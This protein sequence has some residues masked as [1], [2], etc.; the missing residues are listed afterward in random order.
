MELV[1]IV[2][3]RP[4]FIKAWPFSQAVQ[5]AGFKELLVHTGQ[6]YDDAMSDVFFRELGMKAPDVNLAVGSGPHGW[7]TAQMIQG[8]EPLLAA[9]RPNWV[10]VFGDTNTT[11]AGALTAAKLDLPIAHVEAGLRSFR[12]SMPEEINRV[13]T[14]HLSTLLFA[15]TAQAMKNLEREGLLSRAVQVGDI[16]AEA[17]VTARQFARTRSAIIDRL[18][19]QEGYYFVATVH[20]AENTDNPERLADIVSAFCQMPL[21]VIFPVHPRT[22]S[23]IAAIHEKIGAIRLIDPVGYFDML[24]LVDGSRLVLT[25]SGGL[26]KEAYWSGKPCVILRKETEWVELTNP[27]QNQLVGHQKEA[28]LNAVAK[29]L[30]T[31]MP[32]PNPNPLLDLRG[33]ASRICSA[34]ALAAIPEQS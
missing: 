19:L 1:T 12:R 16:M 27:G 26:Q 15:P 4:Q 29:L 32:T 21:P 10:I 7:Q 2:G 9:R 6:H 5:Q 25:D 3:N 14:D 34:L 18:L 33:V 31:D 30:K 8:L 17:W 24:R 13:T 28:I 22:R 20:R 23:K 11:L